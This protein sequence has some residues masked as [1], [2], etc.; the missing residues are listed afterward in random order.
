M[1]AKEIARENM[2]AATTTIP[3]AEK[4]KELLTSIQKKIMKETEESISVYANLELRG[5]HIVWKTID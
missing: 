4:A 2:V 5:R 1:G 3:D